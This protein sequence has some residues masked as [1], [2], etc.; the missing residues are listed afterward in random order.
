[1]TDTTP[2]A[3]ASAPGG[4]T[5]P[6]GATAP[7]ATTFQVAIDAEDPHRLARFW[8]AALGWLIFDEPLSPLTVTG[9]VLIV[10]GCLIAARRG[11]AAATEPEIEAV[12]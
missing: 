2:P 10:A 7:I 8:A 3:D 12:A 4:T 5:A 6:A 9:A 11:K 1:M